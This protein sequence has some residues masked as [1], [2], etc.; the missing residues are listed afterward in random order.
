MMIIINNSNSYNNV[1]SN[2]LNCFCSFDLS[3]SIL[4]KDNFIEYVY[5]V[6]SC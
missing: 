1:I 5:I 2:L 6:L 3:C 4:K